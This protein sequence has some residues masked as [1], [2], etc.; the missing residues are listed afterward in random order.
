[1]GLLPF[2]VAGGAIY[3]ARVRRRLLWSFSALI[4][5]YVVYQLLRTGPREPQ[6]VTDWWPVVLAWFYLG[7]REQA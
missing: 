1:M 7:N 2:A 6:V 5:P 4:P 3:G